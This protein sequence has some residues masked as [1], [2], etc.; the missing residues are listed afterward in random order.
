MDGLSAAHT[1]GLVLFI[2][3]VNNLLECLSGELTLR[4]PHLLLDPAGC[5]S[6][7]LAWCRLLMPPYSLILS[8]IFTILAGW[9]CRIGYKKETSSRCTQ[10][11]PPRWAVLW[12]YHY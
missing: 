1:G 3:L 12:G 10:E 9:M 2:V 6:S 5:V 4:P 8:V 11:I 7:S